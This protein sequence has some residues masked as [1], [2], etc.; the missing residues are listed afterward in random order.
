VIYKE[1]K[2]IFLH[3]YKT[4]GK[5]VKDALLQNQEPT[6]LPLKI[7]NNTFGKFG[8][9][10]YYLPHQ[11]LNSHIRAVDYK[12]Y[13]G[14]ENFN[15]YYKFTIVRNPYDW[16][17]SL[18]H[19]MREK[20][21]HFQHDL[22]MSMTFKEYIKWRCAEDLKLQSYFIYDDEGNKLIDYLGKFENLANEINHVASKNG[23]HVAEV[24]KLGA[25]KRTD[26]RDYYD[27]ETKE[28]IKKHFEKDFELFGYDFNF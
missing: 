12:K 26:F 6:P 27:N 8:L 15:Q 9:R 3:I 19:F 11:M 21:D 22:I 23:L 20:K 4:G 16:Q 1:K 24:K 17:V 18:Y 7:Y 2:V 25:S 28:L 13:L 10:K 14:E 5:T